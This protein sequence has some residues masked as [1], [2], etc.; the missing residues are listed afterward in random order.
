MKSFSFPGE[1][2]G[3]LCRL[4]WVAPAVYRVAISSCV[5]WRIC[6]IALSSPRQFLLQ[7]SPQGT[8]IKYLHI[9][10]SK[11]AEKAAQ[12]RVWY[13]CEAVRTCFVHN[14]RRWIVMNHA[15]AGVVTK[16]SGTAGCKY[17]AVQGSHQAQLKICC[18]DP[19]TWYPCCCLDSDSA[20]CSRGLSPH[21]STAL[22]KRL[23]VVCCFFKAKKITIC[24]WVS[25]QHLSH[26]C[27]LDNPWL[28]LLSLLRDRWEVQML[29]MFIR[30]LQTMR[31]FPSNI[32]QWV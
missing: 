18:G 13:P 30:C 22:L 15:C 1:S 12:D 3:Q 25:V 27:Q 5:G 7:C 10:W 14:L 4:P 19:C 11:D 6:P 17:S 23:Q 16:D 24:P 21:L 31:A 28:S 20:S 29:P 26:L 32:A 2:S 8:Q 9:V